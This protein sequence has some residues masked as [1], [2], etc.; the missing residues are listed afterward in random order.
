MKYDCFLKNMEGCPF[1]SLTKEEILKQNSSGKV[2][3]AKAPYHKG[4]LLIVPNKHTSKISGLT[5]NE[6]FGIFEL[7]IWAE[8]K[9]KKLNHGLS[10]LYRE[11]EKKYIGKSI[12]HMHI[13]IIPDEKI[14]ALSK[15][16]EDR[17]IF[18]QDKYIKESKKMKARLK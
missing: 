5:K 6:K 10:I 12:E 2:I 11:G 3:L 7:I 15:N 18:S 13:H 1:C 4:H 16:N 9:M 17:E 8:R 14:G